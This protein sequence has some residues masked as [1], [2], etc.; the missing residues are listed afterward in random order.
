[1]SHYDKLLPNDLTV[2]QK[3][4]LVGSL[5]G[6]GCIPN[7]RSSKGNCYF[8]VTQKRECHSYVR[9]LANR[10]KCWIT[11]AGVQ[12]QTRAAAIN[13]KKYV[14]HTVLFDTKKHP[15]FNNWRALFYVNK[16]K[17]I[18][19]NIQELLS[20]ISLS[21]WYMDDGS[22]L[23]RKSLERYPQPMFNTCSFSEREHDLLIDAL[24]NK[25]DLEFRKYYVKQKYW[26][27]YLAPKSREQFYSLVVPTISRIPCF[28]YKIPN[29]FLLKFTPG[30]SS[31]NLR[32]TS[33]FSDEDRVE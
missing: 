7:F 32:Q 12:F 27:L 33:E 29:E 5:L 9:W 1:M 25:F 16:V 14:Q 18:P 15:I 10:F 31:Q 28:H 23:H 19:E 3:Q 4:I 26:S 11:A 8:K 13:G 21:V 20:D 17:I 6:D 30:N 24:K 22:L 2:I